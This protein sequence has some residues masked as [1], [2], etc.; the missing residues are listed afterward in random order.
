MADSVRQMLCPGD[1]PRAACRPQKASDRRKKPEFAANRSTSR[2]VVCFLQK[3]DSFPR[4]EDANLLFN[5]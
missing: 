2:I 3:G 1:V 5:F 4:S